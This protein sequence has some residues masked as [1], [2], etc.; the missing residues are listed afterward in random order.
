MPVN[1]LQV[2]RVII[3]AIFT[4]V[5]SLFNFFIFIARHTIN[6]FTKS[7]L[8]TNLFI[9]ILL[10]LLTPPWAFQKQAPTR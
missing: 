2:S 4:F 9:R 10:S 6:L 1:L 5:F 8:D 7:T 3:F